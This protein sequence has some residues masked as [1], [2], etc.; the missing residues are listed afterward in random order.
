MREDIESRDTRRNGPMTSRMDGIEDLIGGSSP[1]DARVR[2]VDHHQVEGRH[3][4][5]PE[6]ERTRAVWVDWEWRAW[7]VGQR[8]RA[9]VRRAWQS[10][11]T[12]GHGH[13]VG[14]DHGDHPMHV[15]PAP[16][17]EPRVP[18]P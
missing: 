14:G 10:L 11:M 13:D 9:A 18:R 3:F 12:R 8:A 7:G 15:T 16:I 4:H 2:A 6:T 1:T 17:D 5:W